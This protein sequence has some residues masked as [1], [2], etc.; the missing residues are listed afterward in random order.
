MELGVIL[1]SFTPSIAKMPYI[2]A[3]LAHRT[4][5]SHGKS[6]DSTSSVQK[7]HSQRLILP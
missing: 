7:Q 4:L 3:S 5:S 6:I 2:L 1:D